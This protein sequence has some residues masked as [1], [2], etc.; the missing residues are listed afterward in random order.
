MIAFLNG[1]LAYKT[2]QSIVINVQGV[3]YE[4]R[5]SDRHLNTMALVQGE[6]IEITT[7]FLPRED[8]FE[9]YG[10]ASPQEK[11]LFLQLTKVSGVGP[12]TALA[13]FS[14]LDLNE[15][16]RAIVSNQP[17]VL[18]QAPGIGAKT[19]QR[20]I[21]DLREKLEKMQ[22]EL[23]PIASLNLDL[24]SDWQEEIELTLIALGYEVGEI[25]QALQEHVHKIKQE[26]NLDDALRI[27]LTL[28]ALPL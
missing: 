15:I 17:K 22:S 24:P 5:M 26:T 16:V 18:S 9:L 1:I 11:E 6:K 3:G 25:Q 28:V 27:L 19:A 4:V 2:P 10:F 7:H 14:C 13:I 23:M 21:L 12:R 8:S 20:I